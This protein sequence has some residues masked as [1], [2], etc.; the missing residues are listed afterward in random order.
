VLV[1]QGAI[2]SVDVR[3]GAPGTR[4]TDLLSPLS[5]VSQIHGV[6][7]CGGSARGL[8]AAEGVSRFLEERGS[9]YQT[10]YGLIPLVPAAVIYD[11]ALGDASARPGPDEGYAAAAAADEEF[12]EGTVGA[13]TGA[14]VGKALV[15]EGWMKGGLGAASLSLPGGSTMAAVTVVNA[16]GDVLDEAGGVLAGA[17]LGERF[18]D[19]RR[20]LL[21]V[22]GHPHFDRMMEH[23][24]L[25][26]I[27]TDALFSKTQCALIARMAHDGLARSVSPVHTPVDGDVVF[28]LSTGRRRSNVFQAGIGAADVVAASIRR[29]VRA[30]D[31]LGP[32]PALADMPHLAPPAA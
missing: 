14:T 1:P 16:F 25:S 8:G 5:S 31:G 10:P 3:G 27:V 30:A 29:A 4:E 28:V 17:R 20:Y 19:S 15:T 26:V 11:L 13:G 21:G 22:E 32:A 23:T 6:T 18:L 9:G 2:A 24:T 12:A 7:L